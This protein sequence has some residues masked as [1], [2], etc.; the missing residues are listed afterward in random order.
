M[1]NPKQTLSI[2]DK[3]YKIYSGS[4]GKML[5]HTGVIGWILSSAAQISAIIFNDKLSK[6][7]KMFLIPQEF[8][9]ACANI[10]S[11]YLVTQTFSS[12]AKKLAITG[13]WIPSNVKKYLIKNNL[14][15]DLGNIN[16]DIT[17]LKLPSR[18]RTSYSRF[19]HGLDVA[20]TTI[21][22]VISCNIITPIIRNIY[23]SKRQKDEIAKMQDPNKNCKFNIYQMDTPRISTKLQ[24]NNT[25][26]AMPYRYSSDLK[27]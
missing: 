1:P 20:A 15:N 19:S 25:F 5:I 21:G 9:D 14:A 7:E 17:K 6:K 24:K 16:F 12:V 8:A 27:V 22:S 23:A 18:I 26:T 2:F 3:L 10:I 11:F 13:K 4:T